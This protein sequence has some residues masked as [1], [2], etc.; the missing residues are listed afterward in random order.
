MLSICCR[1]FLASW[2][3]RSTINM[4]VCHWTGPRAACR[5][6]RLRTRVIPKMIDLWCDFRSIQFDFVA[7]SIHTQHNGRVSLYAR[8]LS[9][10]AERCFEI[11]ATYSS[12]AISSAHKDGAFSTSIP[13]WQGPSPGIPCE[14]R[15]RYLPHSSAS[16]WSQ[17]SGTKGMHL[18]QT[19]EPWCQR[20]EANPSA[21]ICCWGKKIS[22]HVFTRTL[23]K[24]WGYQFIHVLLA[25]TI[26]LMPSLDVWLNFNPY[27]TFIAIRLS[28]TLSYLS[29]AGTC[30]SPFGRTSRL[31]LVL[32]VAGLFVQVLRSHSGR[33]IAQCH[34]SWCQD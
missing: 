19:Q 28:I 15:L 29:I 17:A 14:A 11:S 30:R 32:G 31:E 18:R 22:F 16:W 5:L 33:S 10:E 8:A 6:D 7:R 1:V 3:K 27:F 13:P 9:Q 21:A 25:M 23:P 26:Q 2:T 12:L 20:I 4:C 34:P 24:K